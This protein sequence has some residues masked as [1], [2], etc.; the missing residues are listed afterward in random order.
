MCRFE[1]SAPTAAVGENAA[2][3]AYAALEDMIVTMELKPGGRV[4]EATLS[5]RL[6]IGRTP[7]REAMVRLAAERLLVAQPRRG[8]VVQDLS[9]PL[10]MRVLEARRALELV[11]IPA[12]ARR[13]LPEQADRLE[14]ILA[15]FRRLYGT[16]N[17]TALLRT[18]REFTQVL[19]EMS[20]NPFLA[21]IFPLYSLSRRFWLAYRDL[22]MRR[23]R[24]EQLTL[25]HIQI[26]EAVLADDETGAATQAAR[27]LDFV[28]ECTL[29]VGKE[30]A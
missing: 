29:Y 5:E 22:F 18:D 15:E 28:E 14:R 3:Q 13:R 1:R 17:V 2:E 20:G 12:A 30:L 6:Q 23:F 21:Q 27:F 25:F 4:V 16:D 26:A 7:L 9:F 19:V 24:D 8:M 10:Q 11:L